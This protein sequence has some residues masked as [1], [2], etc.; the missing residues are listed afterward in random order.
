MFNN[1][2]IYLLG[3]FILLAGFFM[4]RGQNQKDVLLPLHRDS[5]V[6][7]VYGLGQI[8]TDK[9]FEVKVGVVRVVK[10]LF[11]KEG[12][13]VQVGAALMSLDGVPPFRAP[14]SG[15]VTSLLNQKGETVFPQATIM[16]LEDLSD[17]YIEVSL[18]QSSILKVQVGTEVLLGFEHQLGEQTR[19]EVTAL[20]S[21]NGEFL[22]RIESD[23]LPPQVMPGMTVDV[24]LVVGRRENALLVPLDALDGNDVIRVR[25][26]VKE[27]VTLVLGHKDHRYAEVRSG[28]LKDSDQVLQQR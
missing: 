2:L 14:F 7:A 27:K 4:W 5:V 25:S 15:T 24:S 22:A 20:Y 9:R 21:R 1:K 12:D 18:E 13:R 28:D 17:T 16:R 10:E 8:K 6:E 19:A 23:S 11:V 26:G 3:F